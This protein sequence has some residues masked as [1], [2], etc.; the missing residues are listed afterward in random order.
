[1]VLSPE[2]LRNEYFIDAASKRGYDVFVSYSKTPNTVVIERD[3][4]LRY[5]ELVNF[6]EVGDSTF[7][8]EIDQERLTALYYAPDKEFYLVPPTMHGRQIARKVL[9]EFYS[10]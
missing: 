9:R 8:L 6:P 7:R 4:A 5:V 3:G 10:L 2:E 1:M